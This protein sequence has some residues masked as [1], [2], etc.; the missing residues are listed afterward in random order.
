MGLVAACSFLLV[1]GC[2]SRFVAVNPATVGPG[3]C[4]VLTVLY[5]K[6]YFQDRFMSK[7]IA[8]SFVPF[9]EL[10]V[11]GV[12]HD[13]S[14]PSRVASSPYEKLLGSF[15]V[16]QGVATE[17]K[18]SVSDVKYFELKSMGGG[19]VGTQQKIVAAM[20]SGTG[21]ADLDR[22]LTT[23]GC[24]CFAALKF[25]YG[26]GARRGSEQF[27]FRKT[28]RPFIRVWGGI[29]KAGS[30]QIV[31]QD[32]LIVFGG[33]GYLGSESEPENIDR[34]E[35]V[36]QFQQLSKEIVKLLVNVLN[37]APKPEMGELVDNTGRDRSY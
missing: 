29:R 3:K 13:T 31:W 35:L 26:L 10:A 11:Q 30:S 25:S 33:K 32:D 15:D 14:G 22:A 7:T 8:F 36:A 1:A 19:D 37:G 21:D 16:L 34:N 9:G 27:G 5:A 23:A 18:A 4:S 17:L 28:Y 6:S 12:N 24:G 2:A 20:A